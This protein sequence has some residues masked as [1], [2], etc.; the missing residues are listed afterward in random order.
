MID[1]HPD[2]KHKVLL[3][4]LVGGI[5]RGD[6]PWGDGKLL[7]LAEMHPSDQGLKTAAYM[8]LSRP[9]RQVRARGRGRRSGLG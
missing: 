5:A 9:W 4:R 8:L 2:A 7:E 1:D 3:Y 6:S